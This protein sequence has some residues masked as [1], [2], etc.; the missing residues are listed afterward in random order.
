MSKECHPT[1]ASVRMAV[2]WSILCELMWRHMQS[3]NLWILETHPCSAQ[4]YCFGIYVLE[5]NQLTDKHICDFN[6]NSENFHVS[7]PYSQPRPILESQRI[8]SGSDYVHTYLSY[9]DEVVDQI[10]CLLGLPANRKK[11]PT[12]PAIL[13]I[14]L[15]AELLKRDALSRR[16]W[17]DCGWYDDSYSAGVR[18]ELQKVPEIRTEIPPENSDWKV[19]AKP[20]S[21]YWILH[22]NTN[23]GAIPY[24]KSEHRIM[25]FGLNGLLYTQGTPLRCWSFWDEYQSNGHRLLPIIHKIEDEFFE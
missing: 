9:P 2:T 17:A 6:I 3:C 25:I 19:Q 18:P 1:F 8:R 12:T 15:I 14:R 10:E 21:S 13:A 5:H 16:L 24:P 4:Y 23:F 22:N 20:A 11:S 7:T